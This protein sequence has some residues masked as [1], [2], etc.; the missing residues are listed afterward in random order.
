MQPTGRLVAVLGVVV[1]LVLAGCASVEL[2]SLGDSGTPTFAEPTT[3]G[4]AE[5]VGD[6]PERYAP[7]DAV[8]L[9]TENATVS[10]RVVAYEFADAYETATDD[11][12]TRTVESP[13]SQQFLFVKV[14]VEHVDGA[15]T[16]TP[17]VAVRPS[18]ASADVSDDIPASYGDGVYRSV[19]ELPAGKSSTG[20]VA[21][22]VGDDVTASDVR[23]A[24]SPDILVTSDEF[25]WTLD[26]ADDRSLGGLVAQHVAADRPEHSRQVTSQESSAMS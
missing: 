11:G 8:E 9:T 23:V 10:V 20:W 5:P 19:R 13:A 2:G 18:N 3:T 24:F 6:G 26:D 16:A 15:A 22:L 12:G 21:V 4:D 1:L 14:S 17:S 7:G 25:R